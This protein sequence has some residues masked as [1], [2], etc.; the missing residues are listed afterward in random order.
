MRKEGQN[1]IKALCSSALPSPSLLCWS[2]TFDR[3]T[4]SSF[5]QSGAKYSKSEQSV[6]FGMYLNKKELDDGGCQ[7]EKQANNLTELTVP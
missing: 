3:S 6:G 1:T 5:P 7:T 4:Y 2:V